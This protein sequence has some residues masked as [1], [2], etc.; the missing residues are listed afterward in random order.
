[1]DAGTCIM[2]VGPFCDSVKY[3]F[4]GMYLGVYFLANRPKNIHGEKDNKTFMDRVIAGLVCF[5]D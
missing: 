1:M 5:S 2:I 4:A 3:G